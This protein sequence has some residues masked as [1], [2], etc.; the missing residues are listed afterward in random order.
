MSKFIKPDM[1]V[2]YVNESFDNLYD[3]LALKGRKPANASHFSTN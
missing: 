1:N 2:D 3:L